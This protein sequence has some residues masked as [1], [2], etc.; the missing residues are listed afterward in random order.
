MSIITC[1]NCGTKNRLD[2]SRAQSTQP[3][4]GKC[5][6]KLNVPVG[7]A[8]DGHP[9]TVTDANFESIIADTRPVLV[10]FWAEWC[11]PCRAIAPVLDQ[12]SSQSEGKYV[13]GKLNVD[14]NQQT[15]SR[16]RVEGIPTLLIFRPSFNLPQPDKIPNILLDVR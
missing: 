10:D 13:I 6:Q 3:V 9:I 11:P 14:E 16:F 7:G 8:Q 1:P 12:L 4:C 5:G 15:A 2:P